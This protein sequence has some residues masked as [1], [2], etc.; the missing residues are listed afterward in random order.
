M[1]SLYV[2]WLSVACIANVSIA[3]TPPNG[4]EDLGWGAPNWSAFMQVVGAL[5]GW[6]GLVTRWDVAYAAP[7]AWALVAIGVQQRSAAYPG[8]PTAST[9]GFVLGYSLAAGC[10]GVALYRAYA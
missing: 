5:L 3:F 10:G 4:R 6:A 8:G 7:I 1:L 2:G 9:A